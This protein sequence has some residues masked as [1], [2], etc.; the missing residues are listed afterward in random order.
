MKV[1]YML[2]CDAVRTLC[3]NDFLYGSGSNEEYE[4]MFQMVKA[5]GYVHSVEEIFDIAEDIA[6]HT[7]SN[8]SEVTAEQ[9]A[10]SLLNAAFVVAVA[11]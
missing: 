1:L 2:S 5:N 9:I 10:V 7:K 6:A 3:I 11:R 4:K 8:V